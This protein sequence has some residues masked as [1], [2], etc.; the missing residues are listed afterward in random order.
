M[1]PQTELYDEINNAYH[2][3]KFVNDLMFL[4]NAYCMNSESV[5]SAVARYYC[6]RT[7]REFHLILRTDGTLD[8]RRIALMDAFYFTVFRPREYSVIPLTK[9]QRC[10]EYEVQFQKVQVEKDEINKKLIE[11]YVETDRLKAIIIERDATVNRLRSALH[12]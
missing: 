4:T 7:L 8:E 6:D 5:L 12:G 2:Y 10:G 9:K 3:S 1:P 11:T